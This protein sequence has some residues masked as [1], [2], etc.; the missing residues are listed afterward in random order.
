MNFL[1]LLTLQ[2]KI[3][4]VKE[5]SSTKTIKLLFPDDLALANLYIQGVPTPKILKLI[6]E[7]WVRK[8]LPEIVSGTFI[9]RILHGNTITAITLADCY[10][11][12]YIKQDNLG[13][14]YN[15]TYAES[16]MVRLPTLQ[17]EYVTKLNTKIVHITANGLVNSS[18]QTIVDPYAKDYFLDLMKSGEPKILTG[19]KYA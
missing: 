2:E 14:F 11:M 1:G 10:Q 16:A 9:N 6:S 18:S 3:N 12:L 4:Y 15:S 5:N 7:E 8:L 19:E 17:T 13:C